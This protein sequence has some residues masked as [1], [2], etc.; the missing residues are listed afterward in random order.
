MTQRPSSPMGQLAQGETFPRQCRAF[1]EAG[2][3]RPEHEG[4]LLAVGHPHGPGA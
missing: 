3:G 4:R 1:S 2:R